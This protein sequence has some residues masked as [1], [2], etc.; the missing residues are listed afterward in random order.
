MG[1]RRHGQ[2]GKCRTPRRGALAPEGWKIEKQPSST[3]FCFK[4]K[5]RLQGAS[6]PDPLT[7]GSAS[8]PRWGIP[9]QSRPYACEHS[10]KSAYG[11][12][13]R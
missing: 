4:A 5:F 6:P 9:L 3:A 1:A 2:E 13:T 7:R 11:K 10:R 8:G 12:R